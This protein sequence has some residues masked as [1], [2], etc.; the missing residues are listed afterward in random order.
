MAA[1]LK[2]ESS[3][4][5]NGEH[6]AHLVLVCYQH[7]LPVNEIDR[8]RRFHGRGL[9]PNIGRYT[10]ACREALSASPAG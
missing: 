4:L 3:Y 8:T 9:L 10:G 1:E 6:A 2:A 7:V 5:K